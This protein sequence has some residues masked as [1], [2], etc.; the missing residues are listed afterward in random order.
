MRTDLTVVKKKVLVLSCNTGGGHNSAGKAICEEMHR[1]GVDC[2]MA[3]ALAF[4]S[5]S[6]SRQISNIYISMTRKAPR[7][8]GAIYRLGD[9]ISSSRYKSPVFFVNIL[10][11]EK[12]YRYLIEHQI[13]DV[14]MTHLFP[15]ET[16]TG[17]RR[18]HG[19][20]QRLIAVS[21]DY[22]C[23][24]FW[25]ETEP[26]AFIIAQPELEE[27]Y[28]AAGI[29]REKLLPYGIP[30][31]A[32]FRSHV[33]KNKAREAIGVPAERPM[34]LIM[35]GSMGF[36]NVRQMITELLRIFGDSVS[37]VVLGGS[38]EKLKSCLRT[39]FAY[40]RNL[41]VVDMTRK[42]GLY[43]DACDVLFTKPG[44][45]TSTEAAVKNVP[46]VLTSPIP[47]CENRNEEFFI[48][49][50]LALPGRTLEQQVE[51]ARRLLSHPS[52]R[53]KMRTLQREYINP[54]AAADICDFVLRS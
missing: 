31:G 46:M 43:M 36:G 12:L 45:L 39:V 41:T 7:V 19:L 11:R 18:E 20:P 22:T 2:E 37:I 4:A 5:E 17:L 34:L 42:V 35:S 15:T 13:T 10:Y 51:S 14:V 32:Q 33:D 47:G 16:L 1:R 25:E 27:E 8:F 40:S 30:V 24:P 6:V 23:I 38:N 48:E 44:G 9:A 53:E 52:E 49:R 29:P 54:G 50:G 3:D 21:T 26:D 28:A